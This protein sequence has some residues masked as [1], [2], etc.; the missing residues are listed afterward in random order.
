MVNK[1]KEIIKDQELTEQ[2]VF[3]VL[4]FASQLGYN[5]AI[6]T[7]MLISQ[8]LKEI[9]LTNVAPDE[10]TLNSA[11]ADPK[12]NE[13][14][15]LEFSQDF[16]QKS[17]SYKK[18]LSFYGNIL[19]F[20]M[21]YDCMNATYKDF[22]SKEYQADLDVFKRFIDSFN[23][24]EQ[25]SSV[26][27]EL[28]RNEA[29]FYVKRTDESSGKLVLQELP[30]HPNWTLINGHSAWGLLYDFNML[31]FI[32]SGIDL[33]GYP[34][35]FADKHKELW[36]HGT[37]KQ[38][39]PFMPANTRDSSWVYWQQIPLDVG[40]CFKFSP[41][42][43]T[44]IPK[45]APLFLD[46]IQQPLMRALQK[47]INLSVAKRMVLGSVGTLDAQARVKDAFNINPDTLGKFLAVVQAAVGDAIKVAA[48]PL[49]DLKGIEFKSENEVYGKYLDTAISTSTGNVNLISNPL[50]VKRNIEETRLSL[51]V[52]EQEM[53]SLY[54]QFE[55]FMDYHINKL[56]KKYKFKIHF[57]G[58]QFYNNREQRLERQMTLMGNGIVMPNKIAAA[59][60]MS[61]FELQRNLDEARANGWTE[62]LTPVVPA[63]Q[64]SGDAKKGRPSKSDTA[65]SESG[66]QTR[67]NGG[68]LTKGG[69][70]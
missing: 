30:A 9:T 54:P 12:N 10:N 17:Q 35:F 29:A 46:L 53:Y 70:K 1:K 20:D 32:Q 68:N 61:P 25:F 18:L 56:T 59:L 50:N 36:D 5:N 57:E 23:Y 63:A 11:M 67:E 6:L 48:A 24:K 52:D 4:D 66:S 69:K 39:T 49:S 37:F 27:G 40:W 3:N 55:N 16:E 34:K 7:P 15:L 44:R 60:G 14:A 45:F 33:R 38:Y 28:L 41:T 19:S 51:N 13:I 64:T 8:R 31:F 43:A 2:E 58:S 21:T 62:N 26:V 42:I 65:L 22:K 47:N